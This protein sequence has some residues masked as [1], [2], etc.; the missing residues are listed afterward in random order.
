VEAKSQNEFQARLSYTFQQTRND[1]TGAALSN[2]PKHLAKLNVIAPLKRGRLFAGLEAQ[3]TARRSTDDG[4]H[5]PG[6]MVVNLT[7]FA[8]RVARNLDFSFSL[9][10]LFNRRY[11]SAEG[12]PTIPPVIQ[13]GRTARV[14]LTYRF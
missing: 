7:A 1:L 11:F 5:V 2:S 4:E 9:F 13:D 12:D 3:Y 6:Y 14:K 8:P 10:N